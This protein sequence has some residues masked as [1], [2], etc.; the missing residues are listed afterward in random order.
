MNHIWII[1]LS[2]FGF[3]TAACLTGAYRSRRAVDNEVRTGLMWLF[4]LTGLWALTTVARIAVPD[5][6]IDIALRIGGL[7]VGLASIG[8]WLYVA[9]A[10]AGYSYHRDTVNRGLLLVVYLAIVIAKLTNPIHN[11]YFIPAQESLPFSHL[12]FN[13]GPLYWFVTGIAYTAVS[14]GLYWLLKSASQTQINAT[15]FRAVLVLTA[16][17]ALLDVFVYANIIPSVIIEVSYAPLGMAI[18]ALGTATVSNKQ[19]YSVSQSWRRKALS[20]IADAIVLTDAEGRIRY[21]GSNATEVFSTLSGSKGRLFETAAPK[22]YQLTHGSGSLMW[23]QDGATKY[24]DTIER[25]IQSS[26]SQ[27][28]TVFAYIDITES[29]KAELELAEAEIERQRFQQAIEAVDHSV[30]ITNVRG[31]IEYV[32]PAF[33]SNT[34]H[35]RSTLIGRS[36]AIL[37]APD[38][39][40]AYPNNLW[41][42]MQETD[43]REAEVIQQRSDGTTYYVQQTITPIKSQDGETTSYVVI[44]TDI[45]E[46]KE[47]QQHIELLSRVLR[48][49]MRNDMNIAR[50]YAETILDNPT[51]SKKDYTANIITATDDVITLAEQSTAITN[52]IID[53]PECQKVNMS[54]IVQQTAERISEKYTQASIEI[55]CQKTPPAR[56]IPQV[57]TAVEELISNAIIHSTEEEISA[58][59][60]I[61]R[62]TRDTN[63]EFDTPEQA[64]SL[65]SLPQP[66]QVTEVKVSVT[67]ERLPTEG[68]VA[69]RIEDENQPIPGMDSQILQRGTEIR[70]VYHGSG[71]GLWLVYWVVMRSD[72]TV[73]IETQDPR[74]NQIEMRFEQY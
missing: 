13:P 9:S 73:D 15:R 44:L 65:V 21:F 68:E 16:A 6:R 11:L 59:D 17:P 50:G 2:V 24:Y 70:S 74:G 10:Y 54:D 29:K 38:A 12:S 32:N 61:N 40:D 20:D 28:G 51:I 4:S 23:D 39:P 22:L 57:R 19:L 47:H 18:F 34:G 42:R 30:F 60:E 72:G 31:T 45:T 64:L 53:P 7:V 14:I 3:A 5:M 56:A 25:D 27:S 48:H 1:Y 66:S 43:G 33:E 36:P 67:V 71:L 63:N 58:N 26:G 46:L 41:E 8:A 62:D 49:N 37:N 52:L 69:V 55:K 35:E